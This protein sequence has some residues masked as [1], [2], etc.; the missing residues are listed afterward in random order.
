MVAVI[1]TVAT[2]IEEIVPLI[3]VV[4]VTV[5]KI[6]DVLVAMMTVWTEIVTSAETVTKDVTVTQAETEAE[7][8]IAITIVEETLVTAHAIAITTVLPTE[9]EDETLTA[10][11]VTVTV[12]ETA[13]DRAIAVRCEAMIVIAIVAE[14]IVAAAVETVGTVIE[15]TG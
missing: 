4:D 5:P 13:Q 7:A 15:V 1:V 8:G 14:L 11:E 9:T 6:E 3:V 2:A 10:A 12:L